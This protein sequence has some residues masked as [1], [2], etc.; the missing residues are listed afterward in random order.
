VA[1]RDA[2]WAHPD[3]LPTGE[4]IDSP[5]NFLRAIPLDLSELDDLE[6]FADNEN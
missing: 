6:P 3:L 2:L 1:G 4:D 5:D